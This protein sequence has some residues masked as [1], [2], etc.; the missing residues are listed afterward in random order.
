MSTLPNSSGI[1]VILVEDDVHFQEAFR[2]AIAMTQ[3]LQVRL[4]ADSRQL[5]LQAL[6]PIPCPKKFAVCMAAVVRSAH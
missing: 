6:D 1:H 4:V 5:A 3:V 2:A